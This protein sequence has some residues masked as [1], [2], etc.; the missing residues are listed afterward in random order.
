VSLS[1]FLR[2][3]VRRWAVVAP[4]IVLVGAA[5]F[6]VGRVMAAT[7]EATAIAVLLPGAGDVTP[8]TIETDALDD[9]EDTE[10]R[11]PY[12]RVGSAEQQAAAA[13]V[14]SLAGRDLRGDIGIALQETQ[15]I[16]HVTARAGSAAAAEDDANHAVEVIATHFEKRQRARGAPEELFL[17]LDVVAEPVAERINEERLR[18]MT[19][20]AA[21]GLALIVGLALVVER[22]ALVS[23]RVRAVTLSVGATTSD[24]GPLALLG[25]FA[26]SLVAIPQVNRLGPFSVTGPM[27]VGVVAGA[28]WAAGRFLPGARAGPLP[29]VSVALLAFVAAALASYALAQLR[30]LETVETRAADRHIAL[31]VMLAGVTLLA[32][33]GLRNRRQLRAILGV[34]VVIAAAQATLGILQVGGLDLPGITRVNSPRG[35]FPRVAGTARHPIDFGVFCAVA[36]PLALHFTAFAATRR[37][38]VAAAGAAAALGAGAALSVTR[39]ALLGLVVGAAVLLAGRRGARRW[40]LLGAALVVLAL[41]PLVVPNFASSVGEMVGSASESPSVQS[42]IAD[43]EPV[44]DHVARH[45]FLGRGTGTFEPSVHFVLDNNYLSLLIEVGLIGVVAFVAVVG[46]ALA[47]A[48]AVRSHSEDAAVRDLALAIAASLGVLAVAMGTYDL[49]AFQLGG[50][51]LFLLLGCAAALDRLVAP[52]LEAMRVE[53]RPLLPHPQVGA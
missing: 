9:D 42:R 32:A 27:V 43:Y 52:E 16:L 31:L 14:R 2:L 24:S 46:L 49:L 18:A 40:G 36:L 29:R 53:I 19:A 26:L 23:R 45:P 25:L 20:T 13:L 34:F 47:A 51:S 50:G 39:S 38:R 4:A 7:H 8:E 11:S 41:T 28:L 33:D 1:A 22:F 5:V 15:P 3:L 10:V 30:L 6:G 17:R 12:L 44:I 35:G 48:R 21:A 37:L